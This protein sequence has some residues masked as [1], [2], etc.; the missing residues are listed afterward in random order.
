MSTLV[1]GLGISHTPSMG[2]E[3]D[4]AREPDGRP[5]P[6]WQQWFDGA[7]LVKRAVDEMHADH[8]VVVYNDHLNYFDLDNDPD[9]LNEIDSN[10]DLGEEFTNM[11]LTSTGYSAS[12]RVIRTADELM[13]QLLVLGR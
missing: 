10:V 6:R 11:I 7:A 13:Q 1:G 9:T 2:L 3:W 5:G 8:M 12:S 4:R